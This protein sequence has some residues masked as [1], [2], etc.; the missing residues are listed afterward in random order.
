MLKLA[1]VQLAAFVDELEKI[2]EA[3][4]LTELELAILKEAAFLQAAR[5]ALQGGVARAGQALEQK[6]MSGLGKI[7]HA[8]NVPLETGAAGHALQ[9]AG[10]HFTSTAAPGV[11]G[12]FRHG[13]GEFLHSKG[14]GLAGGGMK[15]VGKAA[16]DVTNPLGT[17]ATG[18]LTGGSHAASRALK[19]NPAG[20]PHKVLTKVAP[21]VGSLSMGAPSLGGLAAG[22]AMSAAGPQLA[23]M[24]GALRSG[25]GM[26][27]NAFRPLVSGAGAVV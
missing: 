6:G 22:G 23:N 11:A 7:M 8:G 12:G 9:S 15:A 26:L 1:D 21:T 13:V 25:S 17:L 20:M 18:A 19:L 16:L 10:Q 5:G 4:G 24:A 27:V 2:A 14:Q 3:G